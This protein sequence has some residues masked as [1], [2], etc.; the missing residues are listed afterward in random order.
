MNEQLL[1]RQDDSFR[2]LLLF[3]YAQENHRREPVDQAFSILE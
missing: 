3:L 1:T 2:I